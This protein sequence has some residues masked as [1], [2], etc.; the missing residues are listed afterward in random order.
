MEPPR[1]STGGRLGDAPIGPHAIVLPRGLLR[2][3]ANEILLKIPG[4]AALEKSK[5]GVPTIPVGADLFWGQRAPAIFDDIW[6]EFYDGLYFKWILAVPDP[7]GGRAR[8]RVVI[9]GLGDRPPG[10]RAR[11]RVWPK[12]AHENG[13]RAAPPAGVGEI[14]I[15][16][17]TGPIEIVVP[18][19]GLRRW[20]PRRQPV[21]RRV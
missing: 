19:R 20:S 9:D 13:R 11:V 10:A 7:E 2:A 3:G 21:S 5:A 4:W 15:G 17:T 12:T 16:V 18:M 8:F 14:D 6:V 1:M